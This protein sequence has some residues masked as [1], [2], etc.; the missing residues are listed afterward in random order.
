M[1]LKLVYLCVIV[2]AL[3]AAL[4][5]FVTASKS[6]APDSIF[7]LTDGSTLGTHDLAGQVYVVNFWATSCSTC[8]AEMPQMVALYE[9]YRPK[10]LHFIAVAM[11]TDLPAY[12]LRFQSNKKLPFPVVFDKEGTLVKQWGEVN[13]TPTT[14]LVDKTGKIVKKY[15]GQPDF[16]EFSQRIEDLL[17]TSPRI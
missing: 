4:L 9:R 1:R 3:I 15:I 7:P 2:S 16:T 13:I 10:G 11:P 14:F 5:L 17:S 6:N 8:V 12:V